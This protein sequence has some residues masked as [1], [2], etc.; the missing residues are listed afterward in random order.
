VVNFIEDPDTGLLHLH[1]HKP[2]VG[3]HGLFWALNFERLFTQIEIIL[4]NVAHQ[5]VMLAGRAGLEFCSAFVSMLAVILQ[6]LC[7]YAMLA[8]ILQPLCR[9]AML[10]VTQSKLVQGSCSPPG[11]T[12]RQPT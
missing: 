1:R 12:Y 7:Q 2:R 6:C 10:A 5:H 4:S 3:I 11:Y 8:V 9:Y